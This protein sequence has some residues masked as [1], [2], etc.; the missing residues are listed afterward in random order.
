MEWPDGER[1]SS[2][3]MRTGRAGSSA[4]PGSPSSCSPP[5]RRWRRPSQAPLTQLARAAGSPPAVSSPRSWCG[6][7]ADASPRMYDRHARRCTHR[8]PPTSA[9]AL[10]TC[11]WLVTEPSP[12]FAQTATPV[13]SPGLRVAAS[14]PRYSRPRD[15]TPC[16]GSQIAD[17]VREAVIGQVFPRVVASPVPNLGAHPG[18]AAPA[19]PDWRVLQ[20]DHRSVRDKAAGTGTRPHCQAVAVDRC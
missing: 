9:G 16:A 5:P 14:S 10:Y 2:P 12:F 18:G 17:R 20:Q 7:P 19:R 4:G 1:E 13:C 15:L 8:L 3:P 11:S 6:D